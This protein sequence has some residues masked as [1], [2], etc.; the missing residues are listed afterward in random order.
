MR[1]IVFVG[2]LAGLIFAKLEDPNLHWHEREKLIQQINGKQSTWKAHHNPRFYNQPVGVAKNLC[3]AK[4][5]PREMLKKLPDVEFVN[6][7]QTFEE[8]GLPEEFDSATNWPQ[9][10]E[11][12]ND[13]RDQSNCGCCWAFGAAEAA[14]DRLCISTNATYK[15]PLS[16]QDMCFCAERSGC[17][18]GML[19]T[20]WERIKADG[21]VTGGQYQNTGPFGS[22]WCS[23]FSLPHCHHHGPQ[24]D[25]PYPD[26]GDVGCPSVT[27]S[28]RCPTTCDSAAASPHNDFDND[29][30]SFTGTISYLES[31]SAI[32][33]SIYSGGPV[34]TAFTV[35]SDF[36][37]YESG[38]YQHTSGSYLGGH[39]VKI[40]GWG[41]D[42][43]VD[44]WKVA[45]SWNP[46][47]G[48]D[49]Y[50]RIKRGDDNCGIEDGAMAAGTNA[51]WGKM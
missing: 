34:E 21:L 41:T 18:G 26:E 23:A 19:Y 11:V 36:E 20:A 4:K 2:L 50:F 9:C 31:A 29:K 22:G 38:V 39:A 48:E 47:W 33:S 7:S 44:Y 12:I 42:N 49:G 6:I 37:N 16:S 30:Y 40:V 14:S 24:G 15:L 17:D 3:G 13:I 35:Y 32:A 25:D 1:G 10:A 43:G 28:P 8:L 46:Y 27:R 51:K 45:N 5:M